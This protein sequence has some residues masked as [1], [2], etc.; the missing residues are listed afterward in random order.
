MGAANPA[1]VCPAQCG[2]GGY[3]AGAQFS[4]GRAGRHHVG[5]AAP[6]DL[7][8]GLHPVVCV[9]SPRVQPLPPLAVTRPKKSAPTLVGKV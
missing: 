4:G 3:S 8:V 7:D 5:H 1:V 2:P 9:H 6:V